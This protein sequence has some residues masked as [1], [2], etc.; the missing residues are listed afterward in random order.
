[1]IF[2]GRRIIFAFSVIWIDGGGGIGLLPLLWCFWT[3]WVM[4]E[5]L[6]QAM[7]FEKNKNTY[8]EIF[9]EITLLLLMCFLLGFTSWLPVVHIGDS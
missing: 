6:V 9:N 8:M 4:L 3:I 1:M 5:F 2:V 7:P